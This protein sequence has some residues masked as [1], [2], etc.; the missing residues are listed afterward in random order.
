M[1]QNMLTELPFRIR[2]LVHTN[3]LYKSAEKCVISSRQTEM[4]YLGDWADQNCLSIL[5]RVVVVRQW[6]I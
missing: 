3:K 2:I 1:F 5:G 4:G 6:A